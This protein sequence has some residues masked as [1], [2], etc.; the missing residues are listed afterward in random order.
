MSKSQRPTRKLTLNLQTV[1]SLQSVEAEAVA[2]G[3][4]SHAI[5]RQE[6]APHFEQW[7]PPCPLSEPASCVPGAAVASGVGVHHNTHSFG[8]ESSLF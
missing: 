6:A 5:P 2:G 4:A 8:G 3:W 7:H 1:R